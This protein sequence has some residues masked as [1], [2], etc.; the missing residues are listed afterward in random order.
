M[1]FQPAPEQVAFARSV[2]ELLADADTP[3]VVRAWASGDH[4]PGRKLWTRMAEQGVLSLGTAGSGATPVDVVLAFEQLGRFAVPGPYVESAAVLPALG[5][6]VGDAIATLAAPPHVPCALDAGVADTVYLLEGRAFSPAEVIGAAESVDKARL[7][8][9]VRATGEAREVDPAGAF[10]RGVLAVS[11]QL[12][13]L[14]AELLDR[15]VGHATQRRQFGKPIGSF[16]AVKHQLADVAVGLELARPL[17]FGAALA[18]DG[19][20]AARDVSAAKVSCA[21][22]AYRAARTALQVH[23]AIGYTAE[24]DLALWLTK[25]RALVSA[26]G[27]QRFHR[28]RVL[29]AVRDE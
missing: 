5:V 21:A 1:R 29:A 17:L 4:A 18:L 28:N 24:Y 23:G 19:P 10:D 27:T 3:A 16:Q 2:A 11:A 13:G 6:A 20:D 14:G 22:A 26:W 9:E 12:L 7:L 25:V 8:A 15:S